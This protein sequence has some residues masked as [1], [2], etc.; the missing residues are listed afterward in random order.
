MSKGDVTAADFYHEVYRRFDAALAEGRTVLEVNAGELHKA[1]KAAN[2]MPLCCNCMYDLQNIGD[3]VLHIPSGGAGS[4]LLISYSLPRFPGLP[5]ERSIYDAGRV[6]AGTHLR[7][8]KLEELAGVHP[9][10]RELSGIARQKKSEDATGKLCNIA[11]LTADLICRQQKIRADNKKFGTLCAAIE[12]ADIFTPEAVYALH[13]VRIIGNSHARKIP[14]A[15]LLTPKV[16]SC[17][18]HAFLIFA[19][20]AVEKRLIWKTTGTSDA[21]ESCF[22]QPPYH[23]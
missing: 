13:F 18:S 23:R 8:K 12:R 9:V 19:G 2:R 6:P 4:S 20:E 17:A 21:Q 10:F 7:T 14:D 11:A 5:L 16:F 15:C 22:R 3:A 1:L